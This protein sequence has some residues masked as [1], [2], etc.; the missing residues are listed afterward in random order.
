MVNLLVN[1]YHFNKRFDTSYTHFRC[2]DILLE[3]G[4]TYKIPVEH[5]PDYAN[6]KE[7]FKE[8]D[9]WVA[10]DFT[11][12]KS[13]KVFL[14][15]FFA[16]IISET[17]MRYAEESKIQFLIIMFMPILFFFLIYNILMKR[18]R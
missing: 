14:Y 18:V 11:Y 4:H 6:N 7:A 5:H 9:R 12:E 15:V 2:I 13:T 1:L 16:L 10:A 17:F 3:Y 8:K